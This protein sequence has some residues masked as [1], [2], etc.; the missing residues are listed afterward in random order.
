MFVDLEI[1]QALARAYTRPPNTI[2]VL[3]E[4]LIYAMCCELQPILNKR[5]L[6]ICPI[7]TSKR[8]CIRETVEIPIEERESCTSS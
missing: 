2:K 6:E 4:Q 1:A 5:D 8:V 7:C 3:D